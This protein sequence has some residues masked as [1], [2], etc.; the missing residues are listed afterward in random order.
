[1]QQTSLND[2]LINSLV[3]EHLSYTLVKAS[4]AIFAVFYP[5]PSI[6]FS[7]TLP[8][9]LEINRHIAPNT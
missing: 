6:Y 7:N 2:L 5:L 1:M 8:L 3:S 4:N 9:L